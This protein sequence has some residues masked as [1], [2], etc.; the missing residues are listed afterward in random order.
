MR[1]RR[2]WRI[3][4]KLKKRIKKAKYVIRPISSN[5]LSV[6]YT[7]PKLRNIHMTFRTLIAIDP[8]TGFS[9]GYFIGNEIDTILH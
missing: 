7:D 4:H 1:N 3:P 9:T 2:F 8:K 5:K 6:I